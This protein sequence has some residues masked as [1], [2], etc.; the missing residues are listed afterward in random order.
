MYLEK[1]QSVNSIQPLQNRYITS[2]SKAR[3]EKML[4]S[5]KYIISK[6][7][8]YFLMIWKVLSANAYCAFPPQA[9][10]PPPKKNLNDL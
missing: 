1:T 9:F 3:R 8:S 10:P 5:I 7:A 6:I 2:F 4:G